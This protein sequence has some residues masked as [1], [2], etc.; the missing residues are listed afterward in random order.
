MRIRCG[1]IKG[2][3]LNYSKLK[4]ALFFAAIF[5]TIFS[6]ELDLFVSLKFFETNGR[7]VENSFTTFMY[8]SGLLPGKILT[9]GSLFLF[10][11]SFCSPKYARYR[12]NAGYIFVSIFLGAVILVHGLGKDHIHRPRPKQVTEFGGEHAFRPFYAPKITYHLSKCKSFPC[13]HCTMGFCFFSLAYVFKKEKK[14]A[15]FI[16]F[17]WI[18]ILNGFAIGFV[19]IA[20]GGHFFTDVIASGVIMWAAS[21]ILFKAFFSGRQGAQMPHRS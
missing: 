20:Q 6:Q 15:Y 14:R 19:R 3:I 12:G 5:L 16:A 7:F 8:T 13:G 9:F 21:D 10:L 18:A 2:G 4:I 17:L 1:E 11:L